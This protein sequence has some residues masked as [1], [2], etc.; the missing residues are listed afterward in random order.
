MKNIKDSNSMKGF[1]I[2]PAF[3][4]LFSCG[5]TSLDRNEYISYIE[6]VDNGLNVIKTVGEINYSIQYKPEDYIMIKERSYGNKVLIENN[7]Y[8][9]TLRLALSDKSKDILK[10]NISSPSEYYQRVNY[11]SF[12]F[13]DDILLFSGMDTLECSLF[14]YVPSYGLSPS[15][16]FVLGFEKVGESEND[17]QFVLDDKIFGAGIVKLVVRDK[18]IKNIPLLK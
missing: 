17:L 3:L 12:G 11:Y 9:F 18:D 7:M 14:Q 8:Y 15:A 10:Y 13:Q 1:L 4:F 2:I 5:I 16:D 6:N